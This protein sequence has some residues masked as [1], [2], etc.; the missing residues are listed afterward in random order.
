MSGGCIND[1][2]ELW[3]ASNVR[4]GGLPPFRNAPDMYQK[5][6]DATLGDVPWQSF[7]LQHQSCGDAAESP[8]W[9]TSE[10]TV[11]FRDPHQ[12]M[13][14]LLANPAF[15]D[16]IDFVPLRDYDAAGERQYHNF[17]SGDWSW[18]QAVGT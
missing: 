12:V 2:M 7:T 1:L 15:A 6:D 3:T 9:M 14:N 17:M 10:H 18:E 13:K 8:S 4:V 11:W 5:I 16:Q